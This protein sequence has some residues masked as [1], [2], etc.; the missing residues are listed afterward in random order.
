[1]F[2]FASSLEKKVIISMGFAPPDWYLKREK[3][4][5][6]HWSITHQLNAWYAS[7]LLIFRSYFSRRFV[8]DDTI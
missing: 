1:M 4:N 7:I 2:K 8:H 6:S 5:S 3:S